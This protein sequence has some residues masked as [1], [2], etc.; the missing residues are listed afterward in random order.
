MLVP[1]G[2]RR[3][4]EFTIV[5]LKDEDGRMTGMVAILRDVTKR[6]EETKALRKAAAAGAPAAGDTDRR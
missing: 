5:P 2:L 3:P 1:G 4:L 6:F